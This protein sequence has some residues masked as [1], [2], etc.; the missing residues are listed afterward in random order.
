ML[1]TI[2]GLKMICLRSLE[3]WVNFAKKDKNTG[4][5]Q[6]NGT[7]SAKAWRDEREAGGPGEHG[8][9]EDGSVSLTLPM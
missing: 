6:T 7:P 4:K 3:R 9:K 1:T 5:I 8:G 2:P